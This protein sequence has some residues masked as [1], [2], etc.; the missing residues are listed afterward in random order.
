MPY[1]LVQLHV[2]LWSHIGIHMRLLAAEPSST[3]ELLFPSQYLWGTILL[4]LYSMLWDWQF[5]R[6][7]PMFFIGLSCTLF[8]YVLFCFPFHFILSGVDIV[9][10]VSSDWY[11]VNHFL[12]A[13]HWKHFN[14]IIIIIIT[15]IIMIIKLFIQTSKT[16]ETGNSPVLHVLAQFHSGRPKV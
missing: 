10:L 2:V 3:T 16:V 13:L 7:G 12:H 9:G 5:I 6:A 1:V 4:T 8:L 11:R 15:I 14:I